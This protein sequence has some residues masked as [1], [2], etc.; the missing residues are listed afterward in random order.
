MMNSPMEFDEYYSERLH[1]AAERWGLPVLPGRPLIG[2][3]PNCED[4]GIVGNPY[5]PKQIPDAEVLE[6]E[7]GRIRFKICLFT[8]NERWGYSLTYLS[9]HGGFA[10]GNFIKFCDPHPTRIA[11]LADVPLTLQ[12]H[13]DVSAG[14]IR[15][16]QLLSEPHQLALL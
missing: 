4:R 13:R 2:L 16:A 1:D 8:F 3:P 15:W 12:Q 10:Y 14:A 11:A 7:S 6:Y 5:N 9:G